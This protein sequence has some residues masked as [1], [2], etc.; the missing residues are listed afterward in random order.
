[1]L[2]A[3]EEPS[4]STFRQFRLSFF[5]VL[6]GGWVLF[7]FECYHGAYRLIGGEP[8]IATLCK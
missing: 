7:D 5:I 8:R 1:M 3:L 6:W 2:R 4:D